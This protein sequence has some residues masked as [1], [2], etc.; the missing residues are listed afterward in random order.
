VGKT[1]G[2]GALSVGAGGRL[3]AAPLCFK[4][5]TVKYQRVLKMRLVLEPI[6]TSNTNTNLI[7]FV[8]MH[9]HT[10]L[11]RN[12]ELPPEWFYEIFNISLYEIISI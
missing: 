4:L 12:D 8:F 7:A 5:S 6:L 1:A 10:K 11:F 2:L 9:G 3:H